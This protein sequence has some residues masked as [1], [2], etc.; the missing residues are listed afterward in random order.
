LGK[1]AQFIVAI[2]L[3]LVIEGLL[4]AAFPSAAKRLAASALETPETSLRVAG[5]VSAVF[6]LVLV[7]LARG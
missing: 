2:G 1:M 7:W 3:V 4:F 6:G 5:I